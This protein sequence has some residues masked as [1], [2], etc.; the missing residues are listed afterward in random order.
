MEEKGD[1]FKR[2]LYEEKINEKMIFSFI[3]N[4]HMPYARQAESVKPEAQQLL[5]L[6]KD[7]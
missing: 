7:I 1:V 4:I 3:R 2:N 5:D 6:M